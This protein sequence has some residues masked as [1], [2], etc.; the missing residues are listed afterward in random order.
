MGLA[1]FKTVCEGTSVFSGGF[2]S[3][4][5]PLRRPQSRAE[6]LFWG[7]FMSSIREVVLELLGDNIVTQKVTPKHSTTALPVTV[8]VNPHSIYLIG[9]YLT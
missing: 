3:H 2:D 5:P 1:V 8:I 7:L 4:A 6:A 9:S